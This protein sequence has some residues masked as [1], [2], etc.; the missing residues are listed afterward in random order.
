MNG[1]FKNWDFYKKK[2]ADS[3]AA[4]SI[5]VVA[6]S[7]SFEG[8]SHKMICLWCSRYSKNIIQTNLYNGCKSMKKPYYLF[9][10]S[11]YFH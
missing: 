8:M 10:F 3:N 5:S 1:Y 6:F 4:D 9:I 2:N 11:V 7:C